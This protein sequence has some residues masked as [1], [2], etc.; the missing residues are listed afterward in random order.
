MFLRVEERMRDA[1]S[2]AVRNEF[3]E[4]WSHLVRVG[5]VGTAPMQ[6]GYPNFVVTDLGRQLT[7]HGERSPH[8]RDRYLVHVA[9]RAEPMDQTAERYVAE[10]VDAWAAG[11]YRASAV[12]TG[13]ACERLILLLAESTVAAGVGGAP[14]ASELRSAGHEPISRVFGKL[15]HALLSLTEDR[16]LPSELRDALDRRLSAIF[17]HARI[18]RNASGHPSAEEVSADEAEAGLLLFPGFYRFVG[19][20]VAHFEAARP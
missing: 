17:D 20:I 11:L 9:G 4:Y 5:A 15:R 19:S 7:G 3:L 18:L 8:N 14:L 6:P 12:M 1:D 13:V 2:Q 16:A 10:A